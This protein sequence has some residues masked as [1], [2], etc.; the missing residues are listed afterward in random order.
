MRRVDVLL[1]GGGIA[2]AS[3]AAELRAQGF[4]GSIALVTRELEPPYRR[5]PI[6]KDYLQGRS[7]REDAHVHSR[8]WYDEHGVEL[9]TR[10]SVMAL[11]PGARTVTLQSKEELAYGQALLAT[12]AMVRRLAVDGAQLDGIHYLRALGNA[13][14]LRRD[15]EGAERVAIV[16]GSYI[17]TEV[18]ASL[19]SLGRR[20]TIV[21]QEQ[22]VLERSFGAEAGR[23]FHELLESRGVEIV[24]GE[25]VAAFEGE[26]G[27]VAA[28]VCEGGR[29]IPADVVVAGVGAAPDVMLAR[30]AGLELGASGGVRCDSRLRTSADGLWAAGDMCEYESVLHG[31]RLRIEHEDVAAEQ[32][33]TAARNM[34][35]AD[36]PHAAVPYFFSDLAD[37]ASLEYVGP[38]DAWDEVET[39]GS[40]DDASFSFWYLSGGRPV[41]VLAVNRPEDLEEGRR[42]LAGALTEKAR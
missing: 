4:D 22:V 13:D 10:T 11:D 3:A 8:D 17:A 21:M 39:R 1:I 38:A 24:A 40:K 15:A 16:G 6:T 33:R 35:G 29:R 9:L 32:G 34:L 25:S 42:A 20:C 28:V 12:G 37:W 7:T 19:A 5:P 27:R 18:A 23:F 30:R 26:N 14:A 31:R 36:E 2:S 41:A